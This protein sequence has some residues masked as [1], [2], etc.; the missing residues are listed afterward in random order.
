[1]KHA[2]F[3]HYYFPKRHRLMTNTTLH[4]GRGRN[5]TDDEGFRLE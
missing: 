2:A 1:M 4:D 5:H 3:V